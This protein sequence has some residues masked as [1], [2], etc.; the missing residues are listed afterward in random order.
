MDFASWF[1]GRPKKAKI[2]WTTEELPIR[3][4]AELDRYLLRLIDAARTCGAEPALAPGIDAIRRV[5]ELRGQQWERD[6][7]YAF[8]SRVLDVAMT[9]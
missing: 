4:E 7:R 1:R 9:D 8:L 2:R 6:K 5:G 3:D